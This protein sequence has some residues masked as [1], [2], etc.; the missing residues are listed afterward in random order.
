MVSRDV[1]RDTQ[2]CFRISLGLPWSR[3]SMANNFV[4][5]RRGRFAP[6]DF[7]Y[8]IFVYLLRQKTHDILT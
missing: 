3:L 5:F 2:K 6:T 1:L 8:D 4:T 7:T